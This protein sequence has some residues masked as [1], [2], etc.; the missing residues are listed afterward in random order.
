MKT[1]TIFLGLGITIFCAGSLFAQMPE[2]APT[3]PQPPFLKRA[4]DR[5]QWVITYAN[6]SK[7]SG[8]G[9]VEQNGAEPKL[10]TVVKD[11]NIVCEKTVN[12]NNEAL[13]VWHV[14]KGVSLASS[15]GKKWVIGSGSEQ[16]F[17]NVNYDTNDFSGFDWVG[18]QNFMGGKKVNGRPC[19]VFQ[20]KVVT[21]EPSELNRM[22]R[23]INRDFSWMVVDE[24]GNPID[25]AQA[26]ASKRRV[27]NIED[28]K[29]QVTAYIDDETRLPIALVYTSPQGVVTRTYQFQELPA[30][31][32][33]PEEVRKELQ[34]FEIRQKKLQD[35]KAPI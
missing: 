26:D 35:Q 29:T 1:K 2:A 4:P 32:V 11:H 10:K 33:I 7:K 30:P 27:F 3:P 14:S 6:D 20:D 18:V 12:T 31:L 13:Q 28:Y 34:T 16:G 19:L 23:D 22:K 9:K 24:K 5:V 17:D 8:D 25:G 15:D 21:A